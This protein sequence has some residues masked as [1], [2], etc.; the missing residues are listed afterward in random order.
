[1]KLSFSSLPSSAQSSRASV[2]RSLS[3]DSA[4]ATSPPAAAPPR[5]GL[6]FAG[7]VGTAEE[8][9]PRTASGD[10]SKSTAGVTNFNTTPAMTLSGGGV[11][12]RPTSGASVYS[13]ATEATL[14]GGARSGRRSRP[15]SSLSQRRGGHV[16]SPSALQHVDAQTQTSADET[17]AL[18]DA[19]NDAHARAGHE[20]GASA[21]E[22]SGS[23]DATASTLSAASPRSAANGDAA[24]DDSSPVSDVL[25]TAARSALASLTILSDGGAT[26]ARGASMGDDTTR[27]VSTARAARSGSLGQPDALAAATTSATSAA[28]HLNDVHEALRA[29]VSTD[30]RSANL[31]QL[32]Q[33]TLYEQSQL[34]EK[35]E[36]QL[37]WRQRLLDFV[38][39]AYHRD[40]FAIRE[41][42]FQLS[43]RRLH[44]DAEHQQ[45]VQQQQYAGAAFAAGGAGATAGRTASAMPRP[46]VY[47]SGSAHG[48]T[49]APAHPPIACITKADVGAA[50]DAD[51]AAALGVRPD[52][53]LSDTFLRAT[54]ASL[55]PNAADV[56]SLWSPTA[57]LPPDSS[58]S[59]RELMKLFNM[60]SMI[61]ALDKS[62]VD[63]LRGVDVE[64]GQ[65][66]ARF[67]AIVKTS[68]SLV[69][70]HSALSESSAELAAK[71]D[72]CELERRRAVLDRSVMEARLEEMTEWRVR[73]TEN[74]EALQAR[75]RL[76]EG[77]NAALRMGGSNSGGGGGGGELPMH[78]TEAIATMYDTSPPP[79]DSD[80]ASV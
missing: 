25:H 73:A 56:A 11:I 26:R 23:H 7:D 5:G 39:L 40:V 6:S 19:S 33:D 1:M 37:E 3:S 28:S 8:S 35:L 53:H 29:C 44:T 22:T 42:L 57:L 36:A 48:W 58:A 60:Q 70:R 66:K 47:S 30:A 17:S 51:A 54:H 72:A 32:A 76:L 55:L 16:V 64:H 18:E 43:T 67:D 34:V 78:D 50:W 79:M 15:S 62:E 74:L 24:G 9:A 10:V 80:V 20:A 61:T 77:E 21:R 75:V 65:L 27:L 4:L 38:K 2:Q 13:A 71:M 63:R 46:R 49:A 52:A 12:S 69:E 68:Q 59:L 45:H 41:H 14:G 31:L